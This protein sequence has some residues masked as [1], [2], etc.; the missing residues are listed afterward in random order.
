[1]KQRSLVTAALGLALAM[2]VPVAAHAYP[3][4]TTDT[5]NFRAGPGVGYHSYGALPAGTPVNV[6]YCQPGWCRNIL[7]RLPR[8]IAEPFGWQCQNL[9]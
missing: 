8:C 2:A 1:M 6:F 9:R 4:L 3:S 7:Q 5:V